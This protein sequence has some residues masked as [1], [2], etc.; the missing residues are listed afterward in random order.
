MKPARALLRLSAP[1]LITLG[2]AVA[3]AAHAAPGL[4]AGYG[5]EEASGVTATDA[6]GAG[7]AGTI[8]GATRS[9]AG[10]FGAA[11]SFDG[12]NDRVNIPDASPL[13]LSPAMTLSAWVRPT[14]NGWRTVLTKERP[15]GLAYG[16]YASTNTNRPSAEVTTAGTFE[17]RGTAALASNTWSHLSATYDG[18]TLRLY[19]NGTQAASRAV[20]GSIAV[21]SG[22]LR[23]GGN[24]VWGEYFRG[25]IDE[26]R[27]YNRALSAAE[28]QGDMNV[29]VAAGDAVAPTAP[30]NVRWDSSGLRVDLEWDAATDD[31]GVTGYR[32]HRSTVSGFTPDASNRVA[33]LGPGLSH[34]EIVAYPGLYHYRVV[35]AD[36]AGNTTASEQVTVTV[37]GTRPGTPYGLTSSTVDG[38][39]RL[40]WEQPE[41][42]YPVSFRVHRSTSGPAFT[43]D[44]GNLVGTTSTPTFTD[45]AAPAGTIHYAVI[46]VDPTGL[47]S[48]PG[49]VSTALGPDVTPPV[50]TI[51]DGCDYGT[52]HDYVAIRASV[53]DDRPGATHRVLI[54]G[55]PAQMPQGSDWESRTVANGP[56]VLSVVGRDA[57]GNEATASCDIVV[58]NPAVTADFATPLDGA[59][60]SGVVTLQLDPRADGEPLSGYPMTWLEVTISGGGVAT[61][62]GVQKTRTWDTTAVPDGEYTIRLDVGWMDY[63]SPRATKTITVTVEN[64]D[65]TPPGITLEAGCNGAVLSEYVGPITG[66]VSDDRGGDVRLEVKVDDTRIYGVVNVTGGF[67]FDWDT[68]RFA[69]GPHV[70]RVIATDAAGNEKVLECPWTVDNRELTVGLVV[71]PS[72]V[73]G[74]VTVSFPPKA[75]GVNVDAPVALYVDGVEVAKRTTAPYTYDW[76]TTGAAN[77]THTLEARMFWPGYPT[78]QATSTSAVTVH[79]ATAAPAGLVA[80]YG[81]E[82]A[83]GAAVTDS[84]P[85]GSTG[86]ISGAT[87]VTGGRFGSGLAFDGVNDLVNV[88]DAA[89]LDLKT[90]MTLSAWVRPSALGDWRTVIMKSRPGGLAYALYAHTDT[91]RP[92]GIVETAGEHDARGTSQLPLDTWTHLAT[93][94]DGANVKLYVNGAPAATRAATGAITLSTGALQI[95][96]N[97][98]WSEWFKGSIDEVRVYSRALTAEEISA[99]RDRPVVPA[100]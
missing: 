97:S 33:T 94:Y 17:A 2:L 35:A 90:G 18:A 19:V 63:G 30:A 92:A 86:S 11:L 44:A 8:A 80:A 72:P 51:A 4:V 34:R 93:T 3:P 42:Y 75:D 32:I 96:G 88:P 83:S 23:I 50:V 76:D 48:L 100:D 49:R 21:S 9:A 66:S 7:N 38:E 67:Q 40:T 99:D 37:P 57:A 62:F 20:N 95:G 60:V 43:P 87:R 16:L 31:V 82:E 41:H 74:S 79:N 46:A 55:A 59:T 53:V 12:V 70:M 39:L 52:I 69:D 56:H 78:P 28:I 25:L 84:S 68:R 6:S 27:V 1:A 85:S 10:R 61:G 81:F 65:T 26:V 5:F 13:D 64:S 36:A 73:S 45:P 58:H 14:A 15:G 89:S 54:D 98:V 91:N 71:P 22:A 47:T 24:A 29:P 77:G